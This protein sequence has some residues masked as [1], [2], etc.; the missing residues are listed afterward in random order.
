MSPGT[1]MV[2]V[3][4]VN[5]ALVGCGGWLPRSSHTS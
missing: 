1:A 3:L 2:P 5:S 4:V